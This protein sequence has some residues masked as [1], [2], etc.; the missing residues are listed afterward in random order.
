M[1]S[2]QYCLLDTSI[3][4]PRPRA[5]QEP[6]ELST[7][8][9]TPFKNKISSYQTRSYPSGTSWLIK[10][11]FRDALKWEVGMPVQKNGLEKLLFSDEVLSR[12]FL[13]YGEFNIDN[14]VKD[15][16]E[17]LSNLPTGG[18]NPPAREDIFS[19]GIPAEKKNREHEWATFFNGV[20][21]K[22]E[23]LTGI[24]SCRRW[25]AVN[26]T[27]TV[28]EPDSKVSRK[29][30]LGL[31][32]LSMP[33][34]T[35]KKFTGTSKGVRWFMLDSCAE[36]KKN[37]DARKHAGTN[38]LDNVSGTPTP[39]SILTILH[40][41]QQ[42]MD[43]AYSMFSSQPNR[44][45]ILNLSMAGTFIRVTQYNRA[46]AVHGEYFD[47][48]VEEN[49]ASLLR[50]IIG[51]MF[52][53]P[54]DI[55]YDPTIRVK[56]DEK[57]VPTYYV[58]A[59]KKQYRIIEPLHISDSIRGR[60][61]IVWKATSVLDDSDINDESK[62]VTIKDVWADTSRHHYEDFYLKKARDAGIEDVIPELVHAESVLFEGIEDTTDRLSFS[63]HPET[64][65]AEGNPSR[66]RM[67][68]GKKQEIRV[69]RRYVFKGC[70]IPISQFKSKKE[71]L[72][73]FIDLIQIH[74]RL[75]KADLLHRDI[76]LRNVMLRKVPN[77]Q[78]YSGFLI[79]FDYMALISE[80]GSKK[81][82][83]A[84]RT[85]TT[86]YMSTRVLR[87]LD[88]HSPI[89]D[90]ES[91]FYVLIFICLEYSGPGHVRDWDIY[92][93]RLRLWIEGEQLDVIGTRKSDDVHN[94]RN[95]KS[96][97]LDNL[98][99]YFQDLSDC[100]ETM[101]ST[102]VR[103]DTSKDKAEATHQ[104]FI[105]ILEDRL[106]ETFDEAVDEVTV[107]EGPKMQVTTSKRK[108]VADANDSTGGG[109]ESDRYTEEGDGEDER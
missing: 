67:T 31:I 70:G 91:F 105:R 92:K 82:S 20:A 12:T 80:L 44:R 2:N 42:I 39:W 71:L 76:S 64:T 95:F 62:W 98:P 23:I 29:P 81:P 17:N 5:H 102:I 56:S 4:P 15:L 11:G 43:R 85:G 41:I 107:Q 94:W 63:N 1:Y 72:K 89:D 51:F 10:N 30:D 93:T 99:P 101:R 90:L 106:E 3:K 6:A 49:R 26:A 69:H 27:A 100:L 14:L 57:G 22:I 21:D 9:G 78:R 58:T 16:A 86:P 8:S 103:H 73:A 36:E 74:E 54:E 46:G 48:Q 53:A 35:D 33:V 83:V 75:V 68:K 28:P 109:M 37:P 52:C 66:K 13:N 18:N 19:P 7:Q 55:G 87:G 65:P 96:V 34:W 88:I 25:T 40:G 50:I 77:E 108:R 79:D 61:T 47:A 104:D 84:H 24:Q 45:Y 32:P 38:G 60:G 97:V 59:D